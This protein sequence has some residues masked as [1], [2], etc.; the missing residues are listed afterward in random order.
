MKGRTS[1]KLNCR[2]T[3]K[4][5]LLSSCFNDIIVGAVLFSSAHASDVGKL[6]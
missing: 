6:K 3:R 2:I 4:K 1:I 5:N